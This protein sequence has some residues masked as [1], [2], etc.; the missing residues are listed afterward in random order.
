MVVGKTSN[1]IEGFET[2]TIDKNLLLQN[3]SSTLDLLSS[4]QKSQSSTLPT[5]SNMNT[6]MQTMN[7]NKPPQEMIQSM[8]NRVQPINLNNPVI[9]QAQMNNMPMVTIPMNNIPMSTMPMSNMPM[10]TMPMNTLSFEKPLTTMNKPSI[11]NTQEQ[12]PSMPSMPQLPITTTSTSPQI[13][14]TKSGFKNIKSSFKDIKN[15]MEK[16]NNDESDQEDGS[17]SEDDNDETEDVEESFQNQTI[18]PFYGSKVVESNHLRN[19]M[20]AFI[21]SFISLM[22]IFG[23]YRYLNKT[24]KK[25]KILL[26]SWLICFG[27]TFIFLEVSTYL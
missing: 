6:G 4:N 10:S 7:S 12:M 22:T 25:E 18:E 19:V 11:L 8:A 24:M 3:L 21:L 5:M 15:K 17:E 26:V 20:L 1:F 13:S 9:T 27:V 2:V 14:S 16:Q 23:V